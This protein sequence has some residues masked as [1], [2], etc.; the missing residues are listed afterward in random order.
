MSPESLAAQ[1][2]ALEA[3]AMAMLTPEE[4]AFVHHKSHLRYGHAAPWA[5]IRTLERPDVRRICNEADAI[6][7][8]L[9]AMHTETI[10]RH[11]WTYTKKLG[12]DF[13]DALGWAWMG[14]YAGARRWRPEAGT[15]VVAIRAWI[16]SWVAGCVAEERSDLSGCAHHR[17]RAVVGRALR[18]DAPVHADSKTLLLERVAVDADQERRLAA[19]RQINKALGACSP[20]RREVLL[21]MADGATSYEIAEARGCSH[22]AVSELARHGRA[23]MAALV[24]ANM[25]GAL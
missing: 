9:A 24:R 4:S 18:L 10:R 12:C 2:H 1:G 7:W 22:Q 25:G 21:A 14:A 5:K 15:L 16:R 8:Q 17:T 3:Q 13:G 23:A 6:W 19:K 20:S 11:A